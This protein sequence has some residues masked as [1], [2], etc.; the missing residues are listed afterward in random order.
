M[1]LQGFDWHFFPIEHCAHGRKLVNECPD[2]KAHIK[3][4]THTDH[5]KYLNVFYLP[6]LRKPRLPDEKEKLAWELEIKKHKRTE[7]Y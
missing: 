6:P 2:C 7:R 3:T 1:V 5:G 4:A